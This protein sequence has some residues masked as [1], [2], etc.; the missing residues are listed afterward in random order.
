M[1]LIALLLLFDKFY[2]VLKGRIDSNEQTP[3]RATFKPSF[4]LSGAVPQPD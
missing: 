3:G 1:F 2:F 4:G